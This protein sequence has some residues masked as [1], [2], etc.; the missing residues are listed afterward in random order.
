MVSKALGVPEL[1]QASL[2]IPYPVS[3]VLIAVSTLPP[4]TVLNFI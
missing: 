1:N 2:S 4:G 3:T